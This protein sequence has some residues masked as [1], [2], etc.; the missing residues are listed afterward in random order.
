M[1]EVGR[2][3]RVDGDVVGYGGG[4]VC[5]LGACGAAEGDGGDALFRRLRR[6]THGSGYQGRGA[7]VRY[8]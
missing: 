1:R 3:G 5:D 7:E 4:G 8:R 6:R 2:E